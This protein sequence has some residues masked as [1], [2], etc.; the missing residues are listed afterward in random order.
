MVLGLIIKRSVI[1]LQQN[2]RSN[3]VCKQQEG[4]SYVLLQWIGC[5]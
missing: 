2:P 4:H 5:A 3:F 1:L